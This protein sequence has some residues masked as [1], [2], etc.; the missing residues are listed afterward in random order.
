MRNLIAIF[1]CERFNGIL[2]FRRTQFFKNMHF[3]TTRPPT[4]CMWLSRAANSYDPTQVVS[5]DISRRQRSIHARLTAA[6]K[7]SR[8]R[9]RVLNHPTKRRRKVSSRIINKKYVI[10]INWIS[11]A[12]IYTETFVCIIALSSYVINRAYGLSPAS[13]VSIQCKPLTSASGRAYAS[14]HTD[15]IDASRCT[16]IA[17]RIHYRRQYSGVITPSY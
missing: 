14:P 16:Q 10:F 17:R 3:I 15:A 5:D 12:S 8:A 2:V 6:L 4:T 13:R 7:L 1:K 9:K 11:N